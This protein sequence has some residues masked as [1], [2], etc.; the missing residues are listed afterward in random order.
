MKA[1]VVLRTCSWKE[2]TGTGSTMITKRRPL[3]A[4]GMTTLVRVHSS[5][6]LHTGWLSMCVR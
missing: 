1:V 2:H 3:R 5:A 4:M 6:P